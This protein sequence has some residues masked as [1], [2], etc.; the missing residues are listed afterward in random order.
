M[1]LVVFC[2]IT[3]QSSLFWGFR[4][5]FIDD[6]I[7]NINNIIDVSKAEQTSSEC[8]PALS[9]RFLHSAHITSVGELG[10]GIA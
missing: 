2:V 5:T 8:E 10:L 1:L 4:N 7:D 3:E 9:K 6:N